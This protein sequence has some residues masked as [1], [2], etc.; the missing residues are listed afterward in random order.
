[1]KF[2]FPS[3]F[4]WW[5]YGWYCCC[6][7]CCCRRRRCCCYKYTNEI[8][9]KIALIIK[10][11]IPITAGINALAANTVEDFLERALE[12]FNEK[13]K[14]LITKLAAAFFGI[15]ICGLAYFAQFLRGPVT[16]MIGAVYGSFGSPVLGM[17]LLGCMYPLGNKYGAISGCLCSLAVT[18]WLNIGNQ[19]YGRM[20]KPLPPAPI[21]NCKSFNQ[22][23]E[24]SWHIAVTN[25]NEN[26]FTSTNTSYDTN[27]VT[28]SDLYAHGFFINDISYEWYSVFGTSICLLV[29]VL[30]SYLTRHRVFF[31]DP[32]LVFQI[33][34]RSKSFEENKDPKSFGGSIPVERNEDENTC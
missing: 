3:N 19:F 30:V 14:T 20:A 1:M 7:C 22:S 4:C 31:Y 34:R 9:L 6:C 5:C 12:G 24:E 23:L 10:Y 33:C 28:E 21:D 27:P 17:F 11:D 2:N 13:T 18:M 8:L 26:V 15:L 25:E 29:G 32:E 16:Q